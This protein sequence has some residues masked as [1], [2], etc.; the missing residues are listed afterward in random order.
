MGLSPPMRPGQR[1]SCSSQYA[2]ILTASAIDEPVLIKCPAMSRSMP[3]P[4]DTSL[5]CIPP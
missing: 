3:R 5:C 4:S 1:A 2:S